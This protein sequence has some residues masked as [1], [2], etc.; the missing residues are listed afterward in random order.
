MMNGPPV[1]R[2]TLERVR[3]QLV[4]AEIALEEASRIAGTTE[5]LEGG[6]KAIRNSLAMLINNVDDRIEGPGD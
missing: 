6:I 2:E 1:E 3:A 5:W 4:K